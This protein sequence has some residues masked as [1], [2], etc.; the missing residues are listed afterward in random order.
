MARMIPGQPRR[1]DP[2]SR[3]DELFEALR[4]LPDDCLVIHV[5]IV[6]IVS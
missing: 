6:N 3:E 2:T 4:V 1:F 5:G